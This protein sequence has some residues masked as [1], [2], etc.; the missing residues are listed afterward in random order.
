MFL[1]TSPLESI[2]TDIARRLPKASQC[3]QLVV[4]ITDYYSWLKGTITTAK[5]TALH[6]ALVVLNHWATKHDIPY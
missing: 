5:V 4:V 1:A 6:L 2:R 3:N